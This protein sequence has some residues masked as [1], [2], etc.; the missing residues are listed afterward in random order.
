MAEAVW[1]RESEQIMVEVMMDDARRTENGGEWIEGGEW[2]I[3]E[4][5]MDDVRRMDDGKRGRMRKANG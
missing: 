4:V 1:M 3:V 2:I 5:M